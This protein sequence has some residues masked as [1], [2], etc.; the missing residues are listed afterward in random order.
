[1]SH[2]VDRTFEYSVPDQ[3]ILF[4]Y[5]III[6]NSAHTRIFYFKSFGL[7]CPLES[8]HQQEHIIFCAP[9]SHQTDPPYFT[10]EDTEPA[11]DL[12]VELL[13]QTAAHTCI[14]DTLGHFDGIQGPETIFGRNQH[15]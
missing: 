5:R 3:I 15:P 10:F 12:D 11:T 13:K 8:A 14:I 4:R 9:S 7:Q 6:S 2:N 1:M